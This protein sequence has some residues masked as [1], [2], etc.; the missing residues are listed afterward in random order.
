MADRNQNILSKLEKEIDAPG[1]DEDILSEADLVLRRR[2]PINRT[3][4]AITGITLDGVCVAVV[5]RPLIRANAGLDISQSEWSELAARL[6]ALDGYWLAFA[7]DK[8]NER[9][10][11]VCDHLGVAWLYWAQV[12]GG[13]A[14][15]SDFG[16]L[17]RCLANRPQLN[18]EACLLS[19]TLTYP[20]G[21]STC[22]KQIR[23]VSPGSAL[24]FCQG[25]VLERRLRLPAYGDRWA[26]KSRKETFSVL[27]EALDASFQAWSLSHS[28]I[29][30]SVALSSGNDSRYGLGLLLQ[31]GQRPSCATFG[32]P[33]STDVKGAVAICHREH[34]RHEIFSTNRQTSWEAWGDAIQRLGVVSGFQYVAG[35]GQDW[36]RALVGLGG[37]VVLG[38]LGDALSGRHL[39]DRHDGDWL[40]NWEAW[41]LDE[42]EDGSWTGS[43][44]L[45]VEARE[46][47]RAKLRGALLRA[48][49]GLHFSD[50]PQ[51]ALHLDLFCRQRRAT[52]AQVNFLTDEVPIAPLFY[53]RQMIDFWS[54]LGYEDLKGQALYLDYART[55]YPGLFG[56]PRQPSLARRAKGTFANLLVALAPSLRPYLAPPEIDNRALIAQHLNRARSLI[57][58][59]GEAVSHIIDLVA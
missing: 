49:E 1:D 46:Q 7:F 11:V 53:T 42:R 58:N 48:C 16:A 26:G 56:P 32:L 22:F 24:Q 9:L 47:A 2:V 44:I 33:G 31:H 43:E 54:N 13:V 27:D 51:R 5:G 14:F 35:W 17:S 18:D 52:A 25:R 57:R 50:Q 59:Y 12:P 6:G 38:Y 29:P 41:S 30:W 4:D 20:I 55:R 28:S 36:R 19:L 40:A 34:L 37:Q 39:V 10:D 21:D 15:S 3:T 8:K 45:R 23:L